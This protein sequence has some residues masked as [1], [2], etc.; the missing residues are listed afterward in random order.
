MLLWVLLINYALCICQSGN[1]ILQ[2]YRYSYL[3]SFQVVIS[4][5]GVYKKTSVTLG[6]LDILK[7]SSIITI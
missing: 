1:T 6:E 7:V 5:C 2:I 3:L 4:L